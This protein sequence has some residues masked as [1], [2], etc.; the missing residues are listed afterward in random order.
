MPFDLISPLDSLHSWA[1]M[2]VLAIGWPQKTPYQETIKRQ[3][4]IGSVVR[5][6]FERE[7]VV[8]IV[9]REDCSSIGTFAKEH[10][11]ADVEFVSLKQTGEHLVAGHFHRRKGPATMAA[12]PPGATAQ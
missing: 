2:P 11:D 6:I 9:A 8:L 3:F 5:A 7:D 10:F 4:G 12:V 1:R